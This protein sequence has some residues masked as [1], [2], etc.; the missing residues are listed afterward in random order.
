MDYITAKREMGL[1]YSPLMRLTPITSLLARK[2]LE[3]LLLVLVN[4]NKGVK[5]AE[6]RRHTV[7]YNVAVREANNQAA[8]RNDLR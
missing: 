7:K 8:A 1:V 2:C 5:R 4:S 6:L 3:R